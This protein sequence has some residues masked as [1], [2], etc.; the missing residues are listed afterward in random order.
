MMRSAVVIPLIV[1]TFCAAQTTQTTQ[2]TQRS[3]PTPDI[4]TFELTPTAPPVP[5]LKYELTFDLVVDRIPGNAAILYLQ[6][7]LLLGDT[8]PQQAQDALAA[9]EAKDYEKFNKLADEMY[10]APLFAQLDLAARRIGCEWEPPIIERGAE[11]LLPHL[12]PLAHGVTRMIKVRALRQIEQGKVD[13]AL[14][15]LRLGYEMSNKVGREPILISALVSLAITSQMNDAMARLMSRPESPN[16]YWALCEFPERRTI[17]VNAFYG[18]RRF[19]VP[20]TPNLAD[21]LAGKELTPQQ[22]STLLAYVASLHQTPG[23]PP[24]TTPDPVTA[25]TPENLR[26][27]RELYAKSHGLSADQ[28]GKLDKV[29]V[30]GNLYVR[31]SEVISD[32][33]F[34]L[35]ALPYP[36]LLKSAREVNDRMAAMKKQQPGNPFLP[37]VD[38]YTVTTRFARV[39]RQLHALA[40]VEAIRSY[41]AANAGKLPPRLEDVADTPVLDNPLTGRAFEYRVEGDVATLA[42]SQDEAPLKYTIRIR[43]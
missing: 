9:F 6:T 35:R 24:V 39:D 37:M 16:L 23:E 10:R 25:A 21:A 5:A 38:L 12:Q 22:W 8:T 18:E 32:E 3:D 28:V 11:T 13:D 27:A 26:E 7:A 29:V 17:Y 19:I 2:T 40:N 1:S 15:T 20:A 42:D 33:I 31:R 30:L 34:K 14:A 36:V 41:A 4:R 43:R